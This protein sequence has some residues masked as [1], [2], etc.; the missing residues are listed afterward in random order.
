MRRLDGI[1]IVAGLV[2]AAMSVG[3]F[4]WTTGELESIRRTF[5]ELDRAQADREKSRDQWVNTPTP[6]DAFLKHLDLMREL[7]QMDDHRRTWT[8][9]KHGTIWKVRAGAGAAAVIGVGASLIGM[10]GRWQKAT[11]R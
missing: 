1:C 9:E 3:G 7:D 2:V 8:Q 11:A 6:A 4:V 5:A 10:L